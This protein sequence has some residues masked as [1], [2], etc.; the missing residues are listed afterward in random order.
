MGRTQLFGI[1]IVTAVVTMATSPAGAQTTAGDDWQ[2][3]VA[4]YLMGSSLSGSTVIRGR[5]VEVD[6]SASEVFENLKFGAMGV[7]IA[8]KGNWGFGADA[9]WAALGANLPELP[10]DVDSDQG[11]F[12]FYGLRR[13]NEHADVT[14]GIRWNI[15]STDVRFTG[16]AQI[17]L[18]DDKQWVDPI[19]GLFLHS[20]IERRWHVNLY[21]EIGG[22]GLG[23]DIAW[24]IFPTVGI[25]LSRRFSLD[26][27]YRWLGT[28]YKSGEGNQQFAWD[29][30][31]QGP[32]L[33]FVI[34]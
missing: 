17:E 14:F 32:V 27:G 11:L 8:R 22:F 12:A 6:V 2:I 9:I 1:A 3:I 13:L 19:V 5:E 28:D 4:P 23:S 16:P 25:Q 33:G 20:P 31:M 29:V 30:L 34:R 15:L 18:G 24:Q 26:F 21:T 7:V 10:A